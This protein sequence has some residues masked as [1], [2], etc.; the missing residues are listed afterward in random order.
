MPKAWFPLNVSVL[1]KKLE[2]FVH[3]NYCVLLVSIGKYRT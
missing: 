1:A 2:L 3:A